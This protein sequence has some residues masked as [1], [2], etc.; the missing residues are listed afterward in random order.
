MWQISALFHSNNFQLSTIP[1][2]YLLFTIHIERVTMPSPRGCLP[3]F[4]KL[5]FLFFQ[6][7]INAQFSSPVTINEWWCW[8]TTR[9]WW[10]REETQAVFQLFLLIW[11]FPLYINGWR[12]SYDLNPFVLPILAIFESYVI[13][14]DSTVRPERRESFNSKYLF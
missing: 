14:K 11:L 8:F 13:E 1:K 6:N 4:V 7:H 2:Y 12:L 3:D 5:F 10:L 9:Q